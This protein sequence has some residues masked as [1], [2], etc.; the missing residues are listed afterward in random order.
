MLWFKQRSGI[1]LNT[2]VAGPAG[3]YKE[4]GDHKSGE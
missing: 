4:D 2:V 1:R 3:E